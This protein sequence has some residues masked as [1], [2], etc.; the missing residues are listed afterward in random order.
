MKTQLIT[1]MFALSF[2][3][4]AQ[5]GPAASLKQSQ[6]EK[7]ALEYSSEEYHNDVQ[8][9]TRKTQFCSAAG[10]LL[11]FAGSFSTATIFTD[12]LSHQNYFGAM[13]GLG[14]GLGLLAS[15]AI[16]QYQLKRTHERYA[17]QFSP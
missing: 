3:A 7:N 13:I 15:S 6:L 10:V 1:F 17:K 4:F 12:G 9:L 16:T 2:S 5:Y 8:R 11:L 14:S